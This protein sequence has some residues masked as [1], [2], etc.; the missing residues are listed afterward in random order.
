MR[1]FLIRKQDAGQ[2]FDKYLKR[3]LPDAS[4]GFLYKMLRKKNITL[5]DK[6]A[7]GKELLK[8][9]DSV[10]L[11]FSEETFLK[12]SGENQNQ[13]MDIS[14][15]V[16]AFRSLKAIDVIFRNEDIL[17]LNKPAG[18]LSQKAKETDLSVN[19]WMIGY[20]LEE[21]TVSPDSLKR[22]KPSVCNRLDRNT[23]GLILCGISLPGTRTLS[24]LLKTRNLHKYYITY[25]QGCFP[26]KVHEKGYL[27]KDKASNKVSIYQRKEDIPQ[28][29]LEDAEM[30]ETEIRPIAMD[31]KRQISKLEVLLITGKS[32]QI[33]AHLA[34]MGYPILGDRKYGVE[35]DIKRC[36]DKDT[37]EKIH[38]LMKSGYQLLHAYKVVF[39]AEMDERKELS[40]KTFYAPIPD[41]FT[42]LEETI[43][44][45]GVPEA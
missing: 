25:V 22:F 7:E 33:R 2:R 39:P 17:V 11:Y 9:R 35:F 23:S 34:S 42:K 44:L 1:E 5:N 30:I 20:L 21:K 31:V 43:C 32:H 13:T 10:K 3:I 37:E 45:H 4:T 6:K 15:Y 16:N 27:V 38:D 26:G 29:A 28:K 40:G 19:E 12:F 24:K 18:M 8:E 36:D 14:D 41:T